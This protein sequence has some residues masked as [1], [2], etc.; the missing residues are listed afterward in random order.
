MTLDDLVV[1]DTLP[2]FESPIVVRNTDSMHMLAIATG[3]R[4]ASFP[5]QQSI[6]TMALTYKA[7][8][9]AEAL[10]LES[11]FE[12][13]RGKKNPFWLPSWKSQISVQ[14]NIVSGDETIKIRNINYQGTVLRE[15]QDTYMTG[16][17]IFLYDFINPIEFVRVDSTDAID[18]TYEYLVLSSA[19]SRDY[20]VGKFMCGLVYLSRFTN[21]TLDCDW[22]SPNNVEYKI[23][24]T[25]LPTITSDWIIDQDTYVYLVVDQGTGMNLQEDDFYNKVVSARESLVEILGKEVYPTEQEAENHVILVDFETNPDERWLKY[26]YEPNTVNGY[27]KIAVIILTNEA[28]TEY[29]WDGGDGSTAFDPTSEPTTSYVNDYTAL[30]LAHPNYDLFYAVV[31]QVKTNQETAFVEKYTAFKTHLL[32]ALSAGANGGGSYP[33]DYTLYD[34]TG[35]NIKGN[36]DVKIVDSTVNQLYTLFTTQLKEDFWAII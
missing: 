7:N 17:Y 36:Y 9:Q 24:F 30:Q 29:H 4:L 28:N 27:T 26:L 19:V 34:Y 15:K 23:S 11:F 31:N 13:A 6:A 10:T 25:E 8:T 5:T 32:Y 14:Q 18:S 21:D 12:D 20:R 22:I 16:R 2:D 33:I 3:R 1:F 35:I